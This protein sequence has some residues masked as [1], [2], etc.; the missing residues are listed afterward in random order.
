MCNWVE[1][2]PRFVVLIFLNTFHLDLSVISGLVICCWEAKG[3]TA[4]KHIHDYATQKKDLFRPS[5]WSTRASET[6]LGKVMSN[7]AGRKLNLSCGEEAFIEW[8]QS[9]CGGSQNGAAEEVVAIRAMNEVAIRSFVGGGMHGWAGRCVMVLHKGL[10]MQAGGGEE[11][12]KSSS[13]RAAIP[14]RSL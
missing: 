9:L 11:D 6:L 2:S 13:C 8:S 3:W 14:A 5:V 12:A 4:Q 1:S 10:R 7:A